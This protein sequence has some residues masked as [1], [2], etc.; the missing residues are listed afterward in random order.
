M[1]R[2]SIREDALERYDGV[3][4]ECG[5]AAPIWQVWIYMDGSRRCT[6]ARRTILGDR[7][8]VTAGAADDDVKVEKGAA[9]SSTT[10]PPTSYAAPALQP[11]AV[12][13]ATPL[14]LSADLPI[15][16]LA[17]H[18]AIRPAIAPLGRTVCPRYDRHCVRSTQKLGRP[19]A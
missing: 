5:L 18:P 1:A 11:S 16:L 17:V 15:L 12:P 7:R 13:T 10:S 9:T 6:S 3:N 2:V 14:P 8:K 4:P 19:R